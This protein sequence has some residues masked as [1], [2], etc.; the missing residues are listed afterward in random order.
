M[1]NI[2]PHKANIIIQFIAFFCNIK[3]EMK[4]PGLLKTLVI[5]DI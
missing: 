1:P 3:N 4:N 5:R 2:V